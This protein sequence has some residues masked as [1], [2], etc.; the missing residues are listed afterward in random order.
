MEFQGDSFEKVDTPRNHHGSGWH[1]LF[2]VKN[3]ELHQKP[4]KTWDNLCT[5]MSVL[6][7]GSYH[8]LQ[9][10]A[11][12]LEPTSGN[13]VTSATGNRPVAETAGAKNGRRR[14]TGEADGRFK[15][16]GGGATK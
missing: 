6:E 16:Q 4:N 8:V 12:S 3:N 10:N 5:S 14:A 15:Q 9:P 13:Q 7:G 11:Q 2:R 1:G